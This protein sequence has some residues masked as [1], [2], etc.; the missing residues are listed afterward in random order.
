MLD[1][2]AQTDL[3]LRGVR[4]RYG[5]DQ[6]AIHGVDFT[7]RRGEFFSLL[8]PSGCG[9]TTTLRMVAGL[10]EITEGDIFLQGARLNDVPAQ[11]RDVAMVFQDYAL[12]PNYSAFDNMAFNLKLRGVARREIDQRV[13]R[14]AR[15]MNIEHLLDRLPRQLSGGERQ[16]VALGRAL[17][18]E[19]KLFLLDEPLSNLDLKL[20][21]QMRIELRRIH[22]QLGVTTLFVTHDQ[23]EALTLSDRLAV[24]D[25]GR[26]L[27]IGTPRE[28]YDRPAHLFVAKFVGSPSINLYN[29]SRAE[30]AVVLRDG[31]GREILSFVVD[32]E[33]AR[34]LPVEQEFVVGLRPEHF[35]LLGEDTVGAI[36][37]QVEMLEYGGATSFA[38]VTSP[39]LEAVSF[40]G[41]RSVVA[42][43]RDAA[44]SIGQPL[45]LAPD[46]KRAVMFNPTTGESV[47][48][49]ARSV[50]ELSPAS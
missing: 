9:K 4:K 11:K 32:P 42:L 31:E 19:P 45:W 39:A 30:R 38:V 29:A 5:L 14:L 50:D 13:R 48:L 40:D 25:K 3:T 2:E 22:Q 6:W 8:G 23:G 43:P 10:E 35:T 28:V 21:E 17:V 16:R 46:W 26:I 49:R 33:L 27:Q 18:R 41:A 12:Y 7:V 47:G 44:L 15:L 37:A 20:R 1:R 36:A 24:F 34:S